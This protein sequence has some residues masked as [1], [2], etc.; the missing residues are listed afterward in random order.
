MYQATV[1][2]VQEIYNILGVSAQEQIFDG[3][4]IISVVDKASASYWD[5]HELSE[6][7]VDEVLA[8]LA[9]SE[10]G[11]DGREAIQNLIQRKR[12]QYADL[13]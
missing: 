9:K 3:E 11:L 1:E 7:L 8:T 12:E 13:F 5:T 4:I 10:K 6:H 2:Q